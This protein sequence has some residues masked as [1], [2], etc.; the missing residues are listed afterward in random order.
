MALPSAT[1]KHIGFSTMTW[2]PA[3]AAAIAIGAWLP[4][5]RTNTA[6]RGRASSS[7]HEANCSGTR[8]SRAQAARS[9][10]DT[11][12]TAAISKR[13]ASSRR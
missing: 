2:M 8:Y 9:S 4:E 7:C 5:V 1:E 3:F 12:H 10:S 6:S 11:S 13:S